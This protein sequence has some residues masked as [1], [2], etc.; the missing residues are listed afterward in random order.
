MMLDPAE[1]SIVTSGFYHLVGNAIRDKASVISNNHRWLHGRDVAGLLRCVNT[2]TVT[3]ICYKA[4]KNAYSFRRHNCTQRS[5]NMLTLCSNCIRKR[6]HFSALC[7]RE[8][9]LCQRNAEREAIRGC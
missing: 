6:S 7:R 1:V 8:M 4:S 3:W 5:F 9:E 2:N